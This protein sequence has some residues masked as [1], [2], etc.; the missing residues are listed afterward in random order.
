MT[1]DSSGPLQQAAASFEVFK[2]NG[3][4]GLVAGAAQAIPV[5]S[6]VVLVNWLS[7]VRLAHR[8]GKP[9]TIQGLFDMS[10]AVE[11]TLG[12]TGVQV[13]FVL[14]ALFPSLPGLGV[15]LSI[16]TSLLALFASFVVLLAAAIQAGRPQ[17]PFLPAFKAALSFVRAYPKQMAGLAIAVWAVSLL[18]ILPGLV[19]GLLISIPV[20]EG[21]VFLDFQEHHISYEAT[22]AEAGIGLGDSV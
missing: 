16:G 5:L 6:G 22:A 13:A 11:K 10:N 12:F 21:M 15:P 4:A 9:I 8:D 14:A 3:V 18:G 2:A 17:G 19:L 20:A 1:S 7:G